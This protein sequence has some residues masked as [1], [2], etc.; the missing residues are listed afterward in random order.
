MDGTTCR[1]EGGCD[2]FVPPV[3]GFDRDEG[4]VVTGG[5]VYRGSAMSD[6]HGVYLFADY[7]SGRVWGLIRDTS[8]AWRR[9][10]P[11]ETGLRISSFGEDATGELYVVDIEGAIYRL[12]ASTA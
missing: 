3:S 5:Y 9:L 8:S 6:L 12:R 10:G 1:V 11:V 7:C 4:C 2:A